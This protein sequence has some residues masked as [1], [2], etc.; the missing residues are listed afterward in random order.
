MEAKV[1]VIQGAAAEL[2]LNPEAQVVA[3]AMHKAFRQADL[4]NNII[5]GASRVACTIGV[6][7]LQAVLLCVK[8]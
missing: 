1:E 6:V 8:L 2:A 7:Y 5:R 4:H 3:P